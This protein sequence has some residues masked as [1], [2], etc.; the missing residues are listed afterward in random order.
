[1]DTVER[2]QAS[3]L[4]HA[5]STSAPKSRAPIDRRDARRGVSSNLVRMQITRLAAAFTFL[6]AF[7]ACSVS[8]RPGD[9]NARVASLRVAGFVEAAGI[10]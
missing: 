7:S 10:T 9:E 2:A 5:C 4:G 6:A 1:M 8:G 3:G